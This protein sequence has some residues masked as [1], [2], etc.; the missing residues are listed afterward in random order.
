M[1]IFLIFSS[2]SGFNSV[3]K[4]RFAIDIAVVYSIKGEKRYPGRC[5]NQYSRK[6]VLLR[7]NFSVINESKANFDDIYALED[8]RS[9]FSVLGG[10]DYMIPDIA[11]PVIRQILMRK[12][13][14]DGV[15]PVVLDVGCSYGI[16]AAVQRFPLTFDT[17]RRR[18]SG[19]EMAGLSTQELKRLDRNFYAAWPEKSGAKFIGLDISEPAIRY[20]K[21][22]GLLEEGVAVD[23]EN[24][25]LSARDAEV[26]LPANVLLSTGCIGY[27]GEKTY[28]QLVSVTA[29]PP[30]VI[31]FVLRMFPY[32][33][34]A[35]A[36]SEIGL[37]TERLAGVTFVQRR[38]R[39]AEEFEGS[40]AALAAVGIETDGLESEGVYH[41]E[42]YLSRP[43][44][45][46]RAC[47]LEDIVN[48]TSGRNR[49]VGPRYVHVETSR[50]LEVALE[51]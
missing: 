24:G 30:W 2:L 38:F 33:K 1:H 25:S 49:P 27:V 10:M 20:A 7:D 8:P 13:Q 18:Y 48:I 35:S 50:G 19:R 42:L 41:A 21:S 12:A 16:N 40:L 9:Y 34:M 3:F 6:D 4:L 51:P 23:L 11:A 22:V 47:P 39:D 5:E 28:R 44:D 32:D 46:V 37:V 31:S 45:D 26:L 15:D 14:T 29:T 43:G 17:L 36:L